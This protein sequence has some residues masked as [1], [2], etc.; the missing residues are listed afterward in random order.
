MK[1]EES[2]PGAAARE[3]LAQATPADTSLSSELGTD[4]AGYSFADEEMMQS[5]NFVFSGKYKPGVIAIAWSFLTFEAN[6]ENQ[7]TY[8]LQ[9]TTIHITEVLRM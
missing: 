6:S 3:L 4:S 8:T 5:P 2:W 7:S 1:E 9:I